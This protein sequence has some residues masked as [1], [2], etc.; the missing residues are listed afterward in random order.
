MAST[1]ARTEQL[2]YPEARARVLAAARPLPAETI[3]TADGRGRALRRRVTAA[4]PLTP[5]RNSSMD[6]FAV[7]AADLARAGER[8]PAVLPVVETLPAGHTPTRALASGEA[9]RIMTGAMLPEGADAVI[10]VEEAEAIRSPDGRERV[11]IARPARAHENVRDAGL[12]L[13]TGAT[14]LEEGREL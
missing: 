4:H 5:F 14:A 2:T 3:A 12:D 6:G 7:R 13:A 10:P 11:R 9:M 8:S 1:A